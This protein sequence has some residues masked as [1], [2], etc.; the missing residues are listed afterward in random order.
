MARL[1]PRPDQIAAHHRDIG[2]NFA[3]SDRA[4]K[5]VRSQREDIGGI[6]SRSGALT[7]LVHHLQGEPYALRGPG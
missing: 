4:L 1:D 2:V 5:G 3:A 6:E 7:R